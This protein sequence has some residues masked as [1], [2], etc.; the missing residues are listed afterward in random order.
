[1]LLEDQMLLVL[2][3]DMIF[4]PGLLTKWLVNSKCALKT[5]M[6]Y[7]IIF[8]IFLPKVGF[9]FQW[10]GNIDF[11]LGFKTL[12]Q[13]DWAPAYTNGAT[14]IAG[15]FKKTTWPVEITF[16][17]LYSK[18]HQF[19]Y[20]PNEHITSNGAGNIYIPP[21]TYKEYIFES[22]EINWGVRKKWVSF[23]T[24][25]PFVSGGLSWV[26]NESRLNGISRP[27][28]YNQ[29]HG[30]GIGAFVG[31]GFYLLLHPHFN[32]GIEFRYTSAQSTL[33]EKIKVEGGGRHFRMMMG[34]KW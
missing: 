13:E 5:A 26:R 23:K 22:Y 7:V 29:M 9:G 19:E 25:S 31:C 18:G 28:I 20:S 1:M 30:T 27:E 10:N 4:K 15:N 2:V 32:V 11:L 16:D 33:D 12:H 8:T 6:L 34:Y 3:S 21:H 17:F 14:G 24:A